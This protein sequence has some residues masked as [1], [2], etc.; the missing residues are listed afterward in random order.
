MTRPTR[1]TLESRLKYVDLLTALGQSFNASWNIVTW[2]QGRYA[3]RQYQVKI[4]ATDEIFS[5]L[6]MKLMEL[7]PKREVNRDLAVITTRKDRVD[8]TSLQQLLGRGKRKIEHRDVHVFY[9]GDKPITFYLRG[10][11]IRMRME[12][13][14]IASKPNEP[15]KLRASVPQVILTA[16]DQPGCDMLLKFIREV[17]HEYER[18]RIGSRLWTAAKWGEWSREPSVPERRIETVILAPGVT[19]FLVSDVQKFI[20]SEAD[21]DRLGIPWHRGYVF[22]GPPGTG[23][24][25]IARG[26]S[27]RFELDLYLM[28]LHDLEE[29]TSLIQLITSIQPRSILLIEDVDISSAATTRAEKKSTISMSGLLNALDGV[30][31]PHGLITMMMTNDVTKLDPAVL[32]P[33]RADVKQHIGYMV[34]PQLNALVE[35]IVG[36][37][38]SVSELLD[39]GDRNLTPAEVIE[40]AKFYLDDPDQAYKIIRENLDA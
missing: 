36:R 2:V 11:K 28:A 19:D 13:P 12:K 9:D 20:E 23:K 18:A 27:S 17:A 22:H 4:E 10:H 32:R 39:V 26:L 5:L 16:S 35:L 37:K 7:A 21:Y 6:M 8:A 15:K 38:L 34:T 33:G 31:T 30:A 1:K 40:W 24:T 29:D 3:A 14:D 25:S